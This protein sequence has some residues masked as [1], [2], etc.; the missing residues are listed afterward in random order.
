MIRNECWFMR[1]FRKCPWAEFCLTCGHFL[2]YR[3]QCPDD[4]VVVTSADSPW[5]KG[6]RHSVFGGRR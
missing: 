5:V 1:T 3:S 2:S 6:R 4:H